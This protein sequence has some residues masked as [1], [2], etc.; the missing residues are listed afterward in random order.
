MIKSIIDPFPP[1]DYV[2]T[3]SALPGIE[4]YKPAPPE[5]DPHKE[6]VDFNCP[7]CGAKTAYSAADGGLTCSFCGYF[8]KPQAKVVGKK[9]EQFEFTVETMARSVQ[10]WGKDRKEMACQNCGAQTSIPEGSL[11][12][13][14]AFC[15]SN[16]VIQRRAPQD[17]LRPRFLIPFSIQESECQEITRNWLGS[18]WMTPAS[19]KQINS[20]SAF[21]GIY[22]P[23]WTFDA[24]TSA[25]WKAQVGHLKTERYYQDG[26]WKTRT[27]IEWRWESGSVSLNI[28]DLLVQGSSRLSEVLLDKIDD[29]RIKDL[30][31]Y[32]PN[33]L[34]GLQAQ[35]YDI[36]LERAWEI[37]RKRMREQTREACMKQA[38]TSMVRN[39]SMTLDFAEESWRYILLPIYLTTFRYEAKSY[40][41]MINAQTGSIAGSRPVDWAKIWLVIALLLTPGLILG[42][43]GL[44]TIPFAGIGLAIGG[45]GFILLII[46]VVIGFIIWRQAEALDDV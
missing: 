17:I 32:D 21:T 41:L 2:P 24:Q 26:K 6:I 27:K 36:P 11:T 16:K 44:V 37:G 33:Y 25:D 40:Q 5:S 34:A 7:Q 20:L 29:F 3:H 12:Y 35:A 23:Y 31:P 18:S 14:C 46:G 28:D 4:V 38:S 13:T 15:G 43:I 30:V 1:A 45:V 19:L 22:L 42:L 8:E 9:A 39:F 10:G